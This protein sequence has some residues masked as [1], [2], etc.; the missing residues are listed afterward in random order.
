MSTRPVFIYAATYESPET[1]RED[2]QMLRD[3]HAIRARQTNIQEH[4]V[5]LMRAGGGP[6]VATNRDPVAHTTS[7]RRRLS[8]GC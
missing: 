5:G 7:L 3:L 1:A 6:D 8:E 4:H 2:Y